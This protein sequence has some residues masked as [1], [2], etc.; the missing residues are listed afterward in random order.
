[1]RLNL[2]FDLNDP[3]VQ[4]ALGFTER[5]RYV[6]R[7]LVPQG[8]EAYFQEQARYIS[9]HT[10]TAIEGNP[11][12]EADAMIV[13]VEGASADRPEEVEKV[14]L[15]EAYE[16]I[17][18]LAADKSVKV[19]EGL[20]RTLNSMALRGLPD[21]KARRRGTY[22]VGPSLIVDADTR[23][24]RYRPPPPQWVPELMDGLVHDIQVWIKECPGPVAA[25]L[26]HFGV[27]SIH[28]FEDGNGR[29]ARLVAD[30]ILDLTGWSVEGML[31]I[32]KV[33]LDRRRE[34]YDVLKATQGEDF[35]EDLEAK[36][37][38]LFHTY[39]LAGAAALLEERVVSFNKRRDDLVRR[40]DR[41]LNTRQVTAL[42]FMRDIGPLSSSVYARLTRSSPSSALADLTD[43]L[44]KAIV[45][46]VGSGKGTRYRIHPRLQTVDEGQEIAS[47]HPEERSTG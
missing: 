2:S 11:L 29:T 20:I 36:P 23:Q 6:I 40:A 15:Q 26:A 44:N 22:R 5:R 13:L 42:M 3:E 35:R 19:D 47:L 28:P 1:M 30:M 33:I 25:A 38:L 24:V 8:Y 27:I 12:S 45:V 10:S 31:S 4:Q 9:A 41:L 14:N 7:N 17:A 46:R 43:M 39:A 37:F 32:S 34:Y 21:V 18:Q 16:L